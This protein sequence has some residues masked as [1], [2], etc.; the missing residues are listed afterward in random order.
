MKTKLANTLIDAS[1]DQLLDILTMLCEKYKYL[2]DE[3]EFII[4]PKTYFKTQGYYNK[5]AKKVI[6][7]NSWSNFPNKG[8][9][10]LNQLLEKAELMYKLNNSQECIKIAIAIEMIILR[11]KRNH[12]Q[13]NLDELKD[14]YKKITR[15]LDL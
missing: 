11:C 10:G 15:Y 8:I 4:S 7:T 13:N 12:N 6:D 5:L 9:V 2:E 14:L 1:S 3:I